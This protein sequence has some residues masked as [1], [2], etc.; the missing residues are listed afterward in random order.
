MPV[1]YIAADRLPGVYLPLLQPLSTCCHYPLIVTV[2]TQT[3]G[4]LPLVTAKSSSPAVCDMVVPL[5]GYNLEPLEIRCLLETERPECLL[6]SY[7][8]VVEVPCTRNDGIAV[9]VTAR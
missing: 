9:V 5:C 3:G 1:V 4:F 2:N 7:M 6:E 8:R